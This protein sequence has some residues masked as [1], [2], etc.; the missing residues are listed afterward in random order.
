MVLGNRG[1]QGVTVDEIQALSGLK[2]QKSRV[3]G[4]DV[5]EIYGREG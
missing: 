2:Y 1:V 4:E 5:L 3:L